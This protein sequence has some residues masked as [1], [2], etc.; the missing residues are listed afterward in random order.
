LDYFIFIPIVHLILLIPFTINGLG[1]REGTYM[2]I[3]KYYGISSAAAVSFSWID[4]AFMLVVGIA[5][6]IIYIFRK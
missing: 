4:L 5:G 2:E 1:L 6:G 3:F